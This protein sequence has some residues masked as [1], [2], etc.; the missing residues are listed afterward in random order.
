MLRT[1]LMILPLALLAACST[2]AADGETTPPGPAAAGVDTTQLEANHWTLAGAVDSAGAPVAALFPAGGKPMVLDFNQ[3][4]LS[5]R[6]ACNT[7]MGGYR[8]RGDQ[9]HVATLA[10]TMIG[11]PQPLHDQD[12]QF[13]ALFDDVATLQAVDARQLVLRAA[14]GSVLTFHATPTAQ[15]R[16]G[17]PGRTVFWEV[18]AHTRPCPHPLIADAQCLQVREIVYDDNGIKQGTPGAFT[19]FHGNIEGYVHQPG[20]RNVLRLKQYDIANPPA[21]ASGHAY[22]LDMTVE[23]EQVGP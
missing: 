19:H 8:V 16:Y 13:G 5:A 17:G 3:G 15:T 4:R 6:A 18:A 14:N 9:L 7:L 10:S 12:R 21:D 11:C 23:S 20:V 2:T 22:V 1:S